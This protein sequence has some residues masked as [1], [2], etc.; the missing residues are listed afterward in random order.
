MTYRKREKQ[1]LPF[2]R[3]REITQLVHEFEACVLPYQTWTHRAYLAVAVYYSRKWPF[4]TSL[5]RIRENID[6]YNKVCGD[7]RGYNETI[8]IFFAQNIYAHGAAT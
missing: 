8:T 3:D 1:E 7:P 5:A 6:I 4:E 2:L